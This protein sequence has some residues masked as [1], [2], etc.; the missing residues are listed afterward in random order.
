M[1]SDYL[2]VVKQLNEAIDEFAVL[3]SKESVKVDEFNLTWQQELILSHIAK[4]ENITAHE[5][6]KSFDISKS[7][8][9]QVL[10]KLQQKK[11]ITKL[12]NPSNKRESFIKLDENGQKFITLIEELDVKLIENYYSKIDISEFI[13]MT[14]TMKKINKLIKSEKTE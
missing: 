10:T 3:T 14:D 2:R 13:Q 12:V 7:A 11:M 4:H 8:V 6:A 5:I 1:K 9:S